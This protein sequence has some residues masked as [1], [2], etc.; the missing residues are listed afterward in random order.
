MNTVYPDFVT[1]FLYERKDVISRELIF[2]YDATIR[3]R[4]FLSQQ[5]ILDKYLI[6]HT[7][8]LI[9]NEFFNFNIITN[10]FLFV[11][12]SLCMRL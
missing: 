12:L 10:Y 5:D 6:L 1:S 4:P 8:F 3:F 11:L 2:I 9:E 7:N